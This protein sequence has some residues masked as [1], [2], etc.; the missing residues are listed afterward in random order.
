MLNRKRWICE[1]THNNQLITYNCKMLTNNM[2]KSIYHQNIHAS[3]FA[4][5]TSWLN[6]ILT[7]VEFSIG[8]KRT[9]QQDAKSDNAHKTTNK[10]TPHSD[11]DITKKDKI[12]NLIYVEIT[13]L[14]WKKWKK[15]NAEGW[16]YVKKDLKPP[17]LDEWKRKKT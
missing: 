8:T 12:E 2:T 7:E 14:E 11:E 5:L 13:Y 1:Q 6:L 10:T 4:M 17:I 16:L 15:K 3:R 9:L